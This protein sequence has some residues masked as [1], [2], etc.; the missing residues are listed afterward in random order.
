MGRVG[1]EIWA[2]IVILKGDN[3]ALEH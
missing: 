2:I 3:H 1:E